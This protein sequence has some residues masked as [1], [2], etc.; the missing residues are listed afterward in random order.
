MPSP[1]IARADALMQRKRQSS[2]SDD[3]PVLT[4]AVDEE[5][6]PVLLDVAEPVPSVELAAA[7]HL[8]SAHQL[9]PNEPDN[10][11][12]ASKTSPEIDPALRDQLVRHLAHRI[13][14]R[15]TAEL[16]RIIESTLCDFLAEQEMI[17]RMG[18]QD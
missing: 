10:P 12:P 2:L 14:Q 18:T 1:I 13:E 16:P 17:S 11:T 7:I 6:I 5:D 3:I 15:L 8:A 4:D 9:T